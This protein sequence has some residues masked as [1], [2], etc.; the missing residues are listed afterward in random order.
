MLEK[1]APALLAGMPSVVKPASQTTYLTEFV[2]RRIT[3][4]GLLP[5]G[6][7]RCYA[8]GRVICSTA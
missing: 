7:C 1:F 3:E 6:R 4:S 2:V 8:P 5:P